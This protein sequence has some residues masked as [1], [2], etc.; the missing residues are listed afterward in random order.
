MGTTVLLQDQYW[1]TARKHLTKWCTHWNHFPADPRSSLGRPKTRLKI[2]VPSLML[3]WIP[4]CG[5]LMGRDRNAVEFLDT[6]GSNNPQNHIHTLM[7]P[8]ER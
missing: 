1:F 6:E 5:K 3:I 2:I 4:L 8:V 7:V